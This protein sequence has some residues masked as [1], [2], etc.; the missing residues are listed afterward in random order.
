MAVALMEFVNW[1]DTICPHVRGVHVTLVAS[2]AIILV[3]EAN[4]QDT[5]TW[6]CF[7]LECH[8]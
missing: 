6:A 3:T 2:H 8:R 7:V 4:H 5:K 1:P